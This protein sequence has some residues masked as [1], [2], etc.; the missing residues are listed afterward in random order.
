MYLCIKFILDLIGQ[1]FHFQFTEMIWLFS[2]NIVLLEFLHNLFRC[3]LSLSFTDRLND[4]RKLLVHPFWQLK[5]KVGIH[6]KR[7]AAFSRL[8]VNTDNRLIL[9][10]Y[11]TR[12]NRKIRN[13]PIILMALCHCVYT[14]VNR[15]L[16]R[17]GKGSKDKL[18]G[19]WMA[20]VK[21]HLIAPLPYVNDF[22]YIF[23][24]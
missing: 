7:Y 20:H 13:L 14:F 9:T 16:M 24:I 21:L 1:I 12:I 5:P 8:A 17:T 15:I 22:I 11:I 23:Q 4:I 10:P 19:I 3:N 18:S 2:V 6:N